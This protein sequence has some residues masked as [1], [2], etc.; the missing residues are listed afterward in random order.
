MSF[1]VMLLT[2]IMQIS[3]QYSIPL[4]FV[5]TFVNGWRRK[6]LCYLWTGNKVG[7]VCTYIKGV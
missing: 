1:S 4:I 6:E 3:A 2:D 7:M 5:T